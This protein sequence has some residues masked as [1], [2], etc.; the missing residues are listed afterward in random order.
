MV[1]LGSGQL[2]LSE[3]SKVS[4]CADAGYIRRTKTVARTQIGGAVMLVLAVYH[5]V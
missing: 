3:V 5:H 1:D 4:L 2:L